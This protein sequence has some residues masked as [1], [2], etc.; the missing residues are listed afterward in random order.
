MT[1][2]EY[3]HEVKPPCIATIIF[4]MKGEPLVNNYNCKEYASMSKELL[5]R[6]VM[7]T[8]EEEECVEVYLYE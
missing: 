3:L 1:L 4:D 5:R 2:E 8:N 7:E 6:E